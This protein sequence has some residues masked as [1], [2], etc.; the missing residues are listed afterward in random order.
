MPPSCPV[1]DAAGAL[2][3]TD[4]REATVG[5]AAG[6]IDRLPVVRCDAGHRSF[7]TAV[8]TVTDDALRQVRAAVPYARA[9]RLR[10]DEVCC[11]CAQ[12][13]TMPVR[14]T[15]WPVTLEGPGGLDVVLTLRLDLPATRCP[16]CGTDHV[17]TRSQADLEDTVRALLCG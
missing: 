11:G 1:C 3:L 8:P 4:G 5:S 10:R 6:V 2:E 16:G 13:L 9:R 12:P 15:D 7:A 14:R 17:P